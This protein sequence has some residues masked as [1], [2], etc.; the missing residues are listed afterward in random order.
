MVLESFNL[1]CNMFACQD[2]D[3]KVAQLKDLPRVLVKITL[4]SEGLPEQYSPPP[5]TGHRG[6]E[7]PA[8]GCSYS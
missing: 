4:R 1:F 6:E 5:R 2:I 3:V 7:M 8:S